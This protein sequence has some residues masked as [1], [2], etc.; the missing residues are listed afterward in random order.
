MQSQ[1]SRQELA[2]RGRKAE[3]GGDRGRGRL[4]GKGRGSQRGRGRQWQ[5]N[6]GRQA[7]AGKSRQWHR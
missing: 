1:A 6:R 7:I 5:A 2:S 3:E 4:E